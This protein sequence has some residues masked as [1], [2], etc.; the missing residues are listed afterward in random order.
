M[1]DYSAELLDVKRP[2]R[3]TRVAQDLGLLDRRNMVWSW[4]AHEPRNFGDWIGPLIYLARQGR[5][6]LHHKLK[7]RRRGCAYVTAG[8]IMG[9]IRRD[10]A[11]VVWGA[12]VMR[13]TAHFARPK[14]IRAVRGPL[15]R[16]RCLELGY[17][18]PDIYGDPGILLPEILGTPKIRVSHELGII[19]HFVNF[20]EAST[21]FAGLEGVKIVDVRRPVADVVREILS[22]EVTVSSSLHGL[23]ASHAYGR[24]SAL[25][26]FAHPLKGDAVKFFDYYLAGDVADP[27][28]PV[29]VGDDTDVRELM[30]LARS[31]P[32][33]QNDRLRQRLQECCPF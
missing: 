9:H 26:S 4:P 28:G 33:P 14:A 3:V 6:P 29:R 16:A 17:S 20:D 7:K 27:P 22:C 13:R 19:P 25:I 32:T 23:I 21:R 2:G 5:P 11:A 15:T 8:S 18:C 10:D 12:G 24:P 30:R 31:A 1:R